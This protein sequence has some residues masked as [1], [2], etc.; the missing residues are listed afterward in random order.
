M[1]A[2]WPFAALIACCEDMQW[3]PLPLAYARGS[4]S[5]TGK[6][7]REQETE[8]GTLVTGQVS[9]G[10]DRHSVLVG[11]VR[12]Y[13]CRPGM[14]TTD[15]NQPVTG[16]NIFCFSSFLADITKEKIYDPALWEEGGL[17]LR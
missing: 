17:T 9:P 12:R 8:P 10:S 11:S 4:D 16:R 14:Q 3:A 13:S 5:L 15:S 6:G 2:H 1:T 7:V